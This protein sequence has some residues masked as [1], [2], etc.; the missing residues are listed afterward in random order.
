MIIDWLIRS[1]LTTVSD[2]M[3]SLVMWTTS[4]RSW[5]IKQYLEAQLF[6]VDFFFQKALPSIFN[7]I[8]IIHRSILSVQHILSIRSLIGW[9]VGRNGKRNL[10]LLKNWLSTSAL[11]MPRNVPTQSHRNGL[12]LQ[13]L[14]FN[15]NSTFFGNKGSG[16]LHERAT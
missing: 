8:S 4:S 9:A 6:N 5:S 11:H 10:W 14:S 12:A 7:R 2:T 15:H 13:C 16:E 1:W 3:L